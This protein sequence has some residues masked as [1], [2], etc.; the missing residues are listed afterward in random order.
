[1]ITVKLDPG[2]NMLD[3]DRYCAVNNLS[4]IKMMPGS[5]NRNHFRKHTLIVIKR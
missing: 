5:D 2:M 3:I 4:I 1:M